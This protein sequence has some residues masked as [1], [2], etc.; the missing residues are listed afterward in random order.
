MWVP[1]GQAIGEFLFVEKG[2]EQTP[3]VVRPCPWLGT[4]MAVDGGLEV[5][6]FHFL[7]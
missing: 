7:C 3:A 5:V 4:L 1:A 2:E 6:F